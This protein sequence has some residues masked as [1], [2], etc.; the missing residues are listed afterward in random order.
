MKHD[1]GPKSC[2][3]RNCFQ[4]IIRKNFRKHVSFCENKPLEIRMSLESATIEFVNWD[5]TQKCPFAV[6]DDLEATNEASAHFPQ[7]KCRT[8][9]IERQYA[10]SFGAVLVECRK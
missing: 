4:P 3:C 5:K 8:R 2:V 10:A 7:T 6:Y 9:E 1:K